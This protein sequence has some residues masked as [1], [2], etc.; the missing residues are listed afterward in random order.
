MKKL[1]LY[2]SKWRCGAESSNPENRRGKGRTL[3]KNSFGF[4]CCLGQ[5]APQLDKEIPEVHLL[6]RSMPVYLGKIIPLLTEKSAS[7]RV[8]EKYYLIDT[9]LSIVASQINDNPDTSIE[10]KV[11]ALKELFSTVDYELEFVP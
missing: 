10:E 2:E 11:K 9:K 7:A 1:I 5:F 4:S 6:D 8:S 3:L